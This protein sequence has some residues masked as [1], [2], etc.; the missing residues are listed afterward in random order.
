[1]NAYETLI[2]VEAPHFVA[3]LIARRGRVV[4]SAPIL[5]WSVGRDVRDV[6]SYFERRRWRWR[7][8]TE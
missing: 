3:G 8:W 1:M 6:V 5:R 4:Q 2:R 7:A